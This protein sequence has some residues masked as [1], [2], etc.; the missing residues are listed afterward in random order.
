MEDN[1]TAPA[2][3][4][5][6]FGGCAAPLPPLAHRSFLDALAELLAAE[7]IRRSR[8]EKRAR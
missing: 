4:V 1:S 5:P 6:D 7:A 8:G 2:P 3:I